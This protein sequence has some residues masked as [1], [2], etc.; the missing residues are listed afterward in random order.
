MRAAA[1]RL[2]D[3]D[4][5]ARM[6]ALG[7]GPELD[8]LGDS[9]NS[10]A[11]ALHDTERG[12]Q[13]LLSDVAH[14]LRT[15][16]ATIDAYLE[17]LADGVRSPDQDTWGILADQTTRLRRLTEDLALLSRAEEHQLVLRRAPTAA[18]NP[19]IAAVTAAATPAIRTWTLFSHTLGPVGFSFNATFWIGAILMLITFSIQHRGILGTAIVQKVVGLLVII[20]LLIVGVVP[21]LTGQIHWANYSPLVPLATA[22]KLLALARSGGTEMSVILASLRAYGIPPEA[23]AGWEPAKV[24]K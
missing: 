24:E 3:G 22:Q 12:R 17:A 10:M 21:I 19:V 7:L 8:A 9:F 23:P 2:A 5:E 1:G 11:A 16:L 15:P 20:P 14:E 6:P 4:Y 18:N 13:R